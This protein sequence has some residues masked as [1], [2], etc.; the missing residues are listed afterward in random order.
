MTE[1]D[2][3]LLWHNRISSIPVFE[4]FMHILK[5]KIW[6]FMEIFVGPSKN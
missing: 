1:S 4:W 5:R 6:G 3:I 2:E